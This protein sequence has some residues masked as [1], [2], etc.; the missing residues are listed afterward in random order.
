MVETLKILVLPPVNLILLLV[1]GL[2]L[3]RAAPR[4]GLAL[5]VLAI[6]A[7]YGLS[8]PLASG[9]L[10][11]GLEIHGPLALDALPEE[12]QAIVVLAAGRTGNA[13]EYDGDDVVGSLTL[14]R[15]RYAAELHRRTDL[16]VLVAGG[17]GPED[18]APLADLMSRSLSE[19]F[20]I[21][22]EWHDRESRNTA[23]NAFN[24]AAILER[25]GIDTV[26]LVTH[27]WH[28]RRAAWAFGVAG[29]AVVPAPTAFEGQNVEGPVEFSDFVARP[30]GFIRSSLA[31]HEWL[32]ML[33][34]RMRYG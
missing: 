10:A 33:W 16:P 18:A 32:G 24:S 30:S 31:L 28:M 20:G 27:A 3:R 15:L 26:F 9:L 29:F 2:A 6:A 17:V 25:N 5:S 4:L 12:P 11:R 21:G 7:F 8:T 22:V 19:D 1:V 23:E 14:E 13:P 34:Y